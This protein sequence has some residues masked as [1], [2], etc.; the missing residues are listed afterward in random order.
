MPAFSHAFDLKKHI[1]YHSL[2]E[3]D[4]GRYWDDGLH[5]TPDGYDWMGGHIA[6]A[7]TAILRG[8]KPAGQGRS[9]AIPASA[10]KRSGETTLDEESGNPRNINE[11][12]VVVRKHDLY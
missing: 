9:T 11:G 1:P 4:K 7:F 2:S 12:Y 5:L 6:D 8:G 10:P 3:D